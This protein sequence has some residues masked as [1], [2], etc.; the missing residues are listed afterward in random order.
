MTDITTFLATWA[1]AERTRDIEFLD[2]CIM[3]DF[4]G[5]GP[6]GFVLTKAAWLNR[7]GGDALRYETFGVD[8]IDAHAIDQV[9]IVIA[10]QTAGGTFAGNPLPECVRNTFVL[11][12]DG[13]TW[14]IASLQMSFMAG[15]PGAPTLPGAP[16]APNAPTAESTS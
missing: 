7:H 2:T 13:D 11:V 16:P 8:E 10:R 4:V 1:E 6:L 12:P 14:Q 9:A 3:P 15:T 5:V